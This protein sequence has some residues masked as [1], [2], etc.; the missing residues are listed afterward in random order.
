[1]VLDCV[2]ITRLFKELHSLFHQEEGHD[3]VDNDQVLPLQQ[4]AKSVD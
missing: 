1:M 2:E 4:E 3:E